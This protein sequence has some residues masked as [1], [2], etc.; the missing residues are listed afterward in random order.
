MVRIPGFGWMVGLVG[1]RLVSGLAGCMIWCWI[2]RY[3]CLICFRVG[4]VLMVRC[5][6]GGGGCLCGRRRCW[7]IL[8]YFF[9]MWFCRYIRMT[10][11]CGLWN[12]L[13]FS[14]LKVLIM[15]LLLN[16]QLNYRWMFPL[17]GI[18]MFLWRLCYLLGGCSGTGYLRRTIFI[19][20]VFWIKPPCFVCPA[21][22]WRKLQ[23]I[24]FYIVI[25]LRQF[26]IL[27]IGGLAHPRLPR[28]ICQIIS[29]NSVLVV[30]SPRCAA[31]F[32]RLY[33]LLRCGKSGRKEITGSL[34]IKYARLFRW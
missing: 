29:I 7:G 19:V 32:Y 1:W 12:L 9:R 25:S 8:R 15:P 18:K 5:G 4:G 10:D 17:C 22:G 14:L 13:M 20:V 34:M 27:L 26:G 16:L 33:G 31:R 24:Y 11:G 30:V 28:F 3:Q 2:G 6:D 21:A 23:I